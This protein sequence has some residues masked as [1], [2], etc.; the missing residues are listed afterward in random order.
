ME[1]TLITSV[2]DAT[3]K[4]L[5]GMPKVKRKAIGQFFT[6]A[7]CCCQLF[8]LLI[9]GFVVSATLGKSLI[10]IISVTRLLLSI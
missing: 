5:E 4:Y 2:V 7:L 9:T 6:S 3:L 8:T 1:N 10:N